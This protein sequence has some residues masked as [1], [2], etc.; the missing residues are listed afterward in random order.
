MFGVYREGNFRCIGILEKGIDFINDNL[1]EI[2][3]SKTR[4]C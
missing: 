3:K 4:M 1:E 2:K